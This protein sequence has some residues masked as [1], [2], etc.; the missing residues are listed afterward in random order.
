MGSDKNSEFNTRNDIFPYE[1]EQEG[2]VVACVDPS[3]RPMNQNIKQ[4]KMRISYS[5]A[6]RRI[7]VLN[8]TIILKW[9]SNSTEECILDLLW[10]TIG[11][12]GGLLWSRQ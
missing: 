1:G 7:I 9:V 12:S 6:R 2:S 10:L 11:A 8:I 5:W 4:C 3:L